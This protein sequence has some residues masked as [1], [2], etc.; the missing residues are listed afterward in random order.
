MAQITADMIKE[1]R[2]RSGVGIGKCKEALE[3]NSGDMESAIEWLRKAGIASAV[4]KEG[5]ATEEGKI[6]EAKDGSTVA[7][8]EVN[9]ETDFVV[10]N[11]KFQEFA[12]QIA[13]EAAK[14]KPSSLEA[15]LSQKCSFDPKI[16]ID[17]FRAS[18]VQKIGE[19]IQIRRMKLFQTGKGRSLGVYSHLGGKILTVVDIEGSEGEEGLAKDIAMH[20]AAAAPEFLK[21]EEVPHDIIEKEKEIFKTQLKGKPDQIIEKILAGKIN[22]FFDQVCLIKQHYIRDD[23]L[24][25]EAL[26]AKRAKDAGKPL[27]LVHFTRWAVGQSQ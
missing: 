7:I 9:A 23:S 26:V 22:A 4:K 11:D 17:E 3:A 27:Q 5:R 13:K 19:N 16:T 15:F 6:A 14:T 24:T 12:A 8:V 2:E 25:I 21:P 10:N 18:F 1:L 20:V